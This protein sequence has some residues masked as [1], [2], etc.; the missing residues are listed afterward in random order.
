MIE[1]PELDARYPNRTHFIDAQNSHQ[2]L[3][4]SRA[5]LVGIQSWSSITTAV[6]CFYARAVPVLTRTGPFW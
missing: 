5:L 6:R 3:M 1:D 2:A 4:T